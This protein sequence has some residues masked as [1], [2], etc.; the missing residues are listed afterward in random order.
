MNHL[1]RTILFA[2]GLAAIAACGENGSPTGPVRHVPTAP[3]REFV[4]D[5]GLP[6]LQYAAQILRTPDLEFFCAVYGEP[7][8]CPAGC[9]YSRGYGVRVGNRIGWME[10][11]DQDGIYGSLADDFFD[12]TAADHALFERRVWDELEGADAVAARRA[13]MPM[14]AKDPDTDRDALLGIAEQLYVR[15]SYTLAQDLVR[16][17]AVAH[18]EGILVVLCGLPVT[19][20]QDTY[21]SVRAQA[22][23]LLAA[24]RPGRTGFDDTRLSAGRSGR[25]DG[26]RDRDGV[27]GSL[28]SYVGHGLDRRKRR[29]RA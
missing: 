13:L 2:G 4:A 23:V 6:G 3:V 27:A 12:V 9:A 26:L 19:V 17:T 25:D 10:L 11:M 1:M 14:L 5:A 16:N 20:G 15:V 7:Q 28:L 8:D 22:E 21:A 29:A 18:D 24:L